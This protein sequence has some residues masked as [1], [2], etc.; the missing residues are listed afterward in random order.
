MVQRG[1]QEINALHRLNE[2]LAGYA[3]AFGRFQ[4]APADSDGAQPQEETL[5]Q[6]LEDLG[7]RMQERTVELAR[8][9]ESLRAA[10]AERARVEESLR[11]SE[12]NFRLLV[13]GVN[14]YAIF[15]LNPA[16]RIVS[17]NAGAERI[18]GY[19]ANEIIGRHFLSVHV[20]EDIERGEPE[21][22]LQIAEAEGRFESEGRRVRRD[23]S[24][25][26][27]NTIMTAL[28]DPDGRLRGFSWVTRDITER[29]RAE[30]AIRALNTELEQR[31][32]ERTAQLEAANKELEAFSYSVSHDLRAP[33]RSIDG[34]S[35]AL[36]EDYADR[37]DEDG[38][39]SLQRVRAASQRMAELIDDLLELSRVTRTEMRREAVDLSALVRAI[40]AE[41]QRTAPERQAEFII[42]EG[43]KATADTRLLRI[44]LE[45][46]LGNAWKFT[47]KTEQARIEFGQRRQEGRPVFYVRDNGAGFD[48]AYANKLFGAFQRLHGA[49][50][51]PGTGIG[52]A[53]VY[54]IIRR[55]GGQVWAEGSLG[56]GAAFYFTLP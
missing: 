32:V 19:P 3:A 20:G 48:M 45:N 17:W 23:G 9:G 2:E 55:H 26:W 7:R 41:L 42:A 21:R 34:F 33:L 10:T 31:V 18:Y 25:F 39:D 15:M 6:A 44:A 43:L 5:H 51:F 40:T 11:E 35:L 24:H 47:G 38:K 52:L 50:E 37:L 27:A 1:F 29:R 30:E 36:L 46:L 14:D 56:E 8:A 4:S 53:T 54:R 49:T 16:G 12:E 13:E 22:E 28:R